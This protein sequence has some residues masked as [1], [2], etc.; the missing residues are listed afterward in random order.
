[1]PKTPVICD[2]GCDHGYVAI[3]FLEKNIADTCIAMDVNAGPLKH[4]R[5]NAALYGVSGRMELRLS[6]GLKAVRPGEAERFVCAGMGGRLMVRIMSDSKE[7]MRRMKGAVLQPQ[8]EIS[9]VRRYIYESGWH[10]VKEDMV[11]EAD[12]NTAYHGKYYPMM[13]VEPGREPVPEETALTYGPLLIREKHPVLRQYLAFSLKIKE[14][15]VNTLR[16]KN[17]PAG[18][19]RIRILEQEIQSVKGLLREFDA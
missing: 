14:D 11:L 1:M 8:S 13:Y 16:Q 6:D 19:E 3:T 5:R 4:A 15:L 7:V 18:Q 2:V 17:T 10:I 12:G 9:L